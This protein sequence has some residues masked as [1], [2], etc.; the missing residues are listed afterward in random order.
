MIKI[1]QE[2]VHNMQRWEKIFLVIAVLGFGSLILI[3]EYYALGGPER[4]AK[5][6][7]KTTGRTVDANL[8]HVEFEARF[9]VSEDE[10]AA[11]ILHQLFGAEKGQE[12]LRERQSSRINRTVMEVMASRYTED[13]WKNKEEIDSK[14]REKL[15]GIEID[16]I[17]FS[18]PDDVQEHIN[19]VRRSQ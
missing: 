15:P 19:A 13:I 18:F 17:M 4:S 16:T 5:H 7:V 8:V 14:I 10:G 6:T 1:A 12:T 11:E 9:H 2:E 3:N